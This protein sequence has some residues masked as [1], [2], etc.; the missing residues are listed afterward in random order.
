MQ[1]LG[2]DCANIKRIKGIQNNWLSVHMIF[3]NPITNQDVPV[4]QSCPLWNVF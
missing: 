2:K 4:A 1:H 3:L